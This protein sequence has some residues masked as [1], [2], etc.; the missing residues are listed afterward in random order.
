LRDASQAPRGTTIE[1]R[2][3]KGSLRATVTSSE[4]DA[5]D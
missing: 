4:P 2:L 3:S 1:A 5:E